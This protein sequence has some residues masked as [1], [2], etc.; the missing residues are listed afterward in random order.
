MFPEEVKPPVE[1]PA[2]Q[3]SVDAIEG[4]IEGFIL[5]EGT[6]YGVNEVSLERKKEQ[7]HKQLSKK[8]IRIVFDPNTESV[9]LMTESQ[10]QKLNS[11]AR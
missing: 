2:D 1:I 6:D 8:E 3:L 5:R 7:I 9:T 4:I 10:W 11:M